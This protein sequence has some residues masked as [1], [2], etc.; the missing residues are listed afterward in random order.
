MKHIISPPLSSS[1]LW[2]TNPSY[3]NVFTFKHI[4]NASLL[5][6]L[7]MWNSFLP[8]GRQIENKHMF[9]DFH[10]KNK[11][12]NKGNNISAAGVFLKNKNTLNLTNHKIRNSNLCRGLFLR[13]RKENNAANNHVLYDKII[14]SYKHLNRGNNISA[15]S[16]LKKANVQTIIFS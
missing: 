5:V 9:D 15:V 8:G 7:K 12:H 1:P 4:F 16:A 6:L 2:Q 10:I 13:K 14:L 11:D 3:G